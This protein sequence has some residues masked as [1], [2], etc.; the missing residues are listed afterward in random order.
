MT[1]SINAI[2]FSLN[3]S[4]LY[5]ISLRTSLSTKYPTSRESELVFLCFQTFFVARS[6]SLKIA[7]KIYIPLKISRKTQNKF[8]NLG[9]SAWACAQG[10]TVAGSTF[11]LPKLFRRTNNFLQKNVYLLS[12][13]QI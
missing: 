1:E 3:A 9:S 12:V 7:L 8:D 13:V 10:N 5:R 6:L 4:H 2:K 11:V